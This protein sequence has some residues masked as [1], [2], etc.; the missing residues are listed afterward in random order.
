MILD[1]YHGSNHALSWTMKIAISI[2]IRDSILAKWS[3]FCEI[4]G[5][6]ADT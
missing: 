5:N 3:Y 6:Y 4:I 2:E 1:T